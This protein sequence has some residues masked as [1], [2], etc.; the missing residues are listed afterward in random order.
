MNNISSNTYCGFIAIVGKTNVGKSTLLNKLIGEKISITANKSQTTRHKILGIKTKDNKQAVFIDTP[1]LCLHNK[2]KLNKLMNKTI[3][4][5]LKEVDLIIFLVESLVINKEDQV[6]LDYIAKL[7]NLPKVFLLISKSDLVKDHELLLPQVKQLTDQYEFTK[8]LP[9]SARE[10]INIDLLEES[11]FQ[12]LPESPHYFDSGNVT[13][14]DINFRIAEIIR[15]KLIKNVGQELP[16][17]TNVQIEQI[18]KIKKTQHIDATIWV[19]KDGQKKIIVGAS[20]S[21]LKTIGTAARLDLEKLLNSKVFLSLFVKVKSN[22]T[23]NDYN[24]KSLNIK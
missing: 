16:Y 8:V 3:K 21:K 5:A 20:G 23:N 9:I 18:K 2:N 6:V 13:D 12:V 1:G 14:R 11:I 24:L 17:V 10:N 15:E 22:W 7:P 4:S 19:E